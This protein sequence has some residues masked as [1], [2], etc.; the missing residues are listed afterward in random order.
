METS[1]IGIAA[2]PR[3]ERSDRGLARMKSEDFFR[4]LTAELQ[5][6]DP[7]EPAKTSDMIGQV[8]QIRDIE[9]SAKL[10]E[11]LTAMTQ[12]QRTN[13]AAELI[14]KFVVTASVDAAGQAVTAAGVVSGVRFGTD[15]TALLELDNGQVVRS[16]D[17]TLVTTPEEL[18]RLIAEDPA[19]AQVLEG[20]QT[21]SD[22]SKSAASSQAAGVNKLAA[23]SKA[24]EP[25]GFNF[26]L[27]NLFQ[28]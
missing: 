15:G 11:T 25:A 14:G 16:A 27:F 12:H 24:A 1:A 9:L 26:S 6:Q 18:D 21:A 13:G 22:E 10:D 20:A 3:A 2:P 5:Q 4:I 19:L 17:V 23:Q 7:F 8:A 28:G